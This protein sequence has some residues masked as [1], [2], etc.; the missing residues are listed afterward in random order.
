MGVQ[1]HNHY[2]TAVAAFQILQLIYSHFHSPE[3]TLDI[4]PLSV[5]AQDIFFLY[6]FPHQAS[7]FTSIYPL[8]GQGRHVWQIFRHLPKAG[9]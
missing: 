4:F 7:T 3:L 9:W 5:H 1:R 6:P 8:G 2:A